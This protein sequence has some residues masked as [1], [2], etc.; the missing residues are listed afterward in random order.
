MSSLEQRYFSC[1][2]T[3]YGQNP[4]GGGFPR[5]TLPQ[6]T[7]STDTLSDLPHNSSYSRLPILS[8][9]VLSH[10]IYPLVSCIAPH[11]SVDPPLCYMFPCLLCHSSF[12]WDL[13]VALDSFVV[14]V[15]KS[16]FDRTLGIPRRDLNRGR[17]TV[18][19]ATGDGERGLLNG[20]PHGLSD[21]LYGLVVAPGQETETTTIRETRRNE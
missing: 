21:R 5:R 9:F 8:K 4:N 17:E 18:G 15:Y 13:C 12:T 1:P 20:S 11:S 16:N 2:L 10:T 3:L 19:G 7:P 14:V 6:I